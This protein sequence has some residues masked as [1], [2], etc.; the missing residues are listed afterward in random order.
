V[1]N[2]HYDPAEP[3]LD[4]PIIAFGGTDDQR[5]SRER[6]EGWAVQTSSRFELQ[7][8]PGEHFFV[9]TANDLVVQSVS[10]AI[11]ASL[12]GKHSSI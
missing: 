4:C 2:Y 7:Y 5:V 11:K 12:A 8:F 3:P 6:L 9:N 1:E 10:E